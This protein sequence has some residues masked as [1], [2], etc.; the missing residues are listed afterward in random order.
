[1]T[2]TIYTWIAWNKSNGKQWIFC[3]LCREPLCRGK[4]TCL[5]YIQLCFLKLGFLYT[6]QNCN[7]DFVFEVTMCTANVNEK[8]QICWYWTLS[9]KCSQEKFFVHQN[10]QS[11]SGFP[12]RKVFDVAF[13]HPYDTMQLSF[14]Q[15]LGFVALPSAVKFSKGVLS[16]S[17]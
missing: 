15:L 9:I 1:M 8:S 11:T 2:N 13:Q 3:F 6:W 4:R 12:L 5:S 16:D 10:I 14:T 17:I 7:P